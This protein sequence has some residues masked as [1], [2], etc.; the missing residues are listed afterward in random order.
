MRVLAHALIVSALSSPAGSLAQE[1][2]ALVRGYFQ[3]LEKK[4]FGKALALTIGGAKAQTQHMVGTLE[5]E[6]AAH[7]AE[8][9]LKVKKL[10]VQPHGDGRGV[11]VD[12]AIDVVG[13]KWFLHKVARKLSG[14]AEFKVAQNG[15]H[16]EAIDG[17]IE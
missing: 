11:E 7:H 6:A 2:A 10:D 13:K 1:P 5:Q 12:F 4:D 8:V 16:I 14:K 17:N 3:A 15:D 9:E